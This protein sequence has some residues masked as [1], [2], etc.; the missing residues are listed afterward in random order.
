F[1][2]PIFVMSDLDLGMNNWMSDPFKY[3]TKKFDRG[4]VLSAADLEKAGKFGRYADVD[5]DGIP[6]RTLPGTNHPLAAYFTRGSGH[7]EQAAYSERPADYK[8]NLDRLNKKYETA[9]QYVPQPEITNAAGAK[10]GFLAFGTT[11]WAIIESIDQLR[12]EYN[13]PISYYRL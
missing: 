10:I 2:T 3:P 9:R 13:T 5:G 11:H 6:Y 4:K 7:N 12:H 1:Q 8:R